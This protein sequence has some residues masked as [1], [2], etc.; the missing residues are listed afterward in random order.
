MIKWYSWIIFVT[1]GVSAQEILR[2]DVPPE[3]QKCY[4]DKFLQEKDNRFPHTLN[5]LIALI[6]KIEDSND[7][8]LRRLTIGIMHKFRLDGIV[9][10][11]NVPSKPGVSPYAP[12]LEQDAKFRR[13]L[14]FIPQRDSELND[15]LTDIERCSLHFMLS[16]SIE[17]FERGDEN[18]V[19]KVTNNAYRRRTRRA[20]S[21]RPAKENLNINDVETLTPEQIDGMI[22][23]KE[24][25]TEDPN[26]LYP[27]LPPNHPK[28]AQ[29]LSLPPYSDC[30]VENGVIKT[31][32]G[33]VSIGSVIAGIAAGL[34]PET[35]KLS[36][37]FPH[38]A[39]KKPNMSQLLVNNKWIATIAGDLAEV[40]LIQGPVGQK[41]TIG[42]NGN[43]NSSAEPH[44][45]FLKS[46]N[47]LEFT[48]A[49][50]RG[51][52][53]GL[54]LANEIETLYSRVPTLKLSQI[55]EMYYGAHGLFDHSIRACNRGI[56]FTTM[57]SNA[58][59]TMFAQTYSASMA[60]KEDL[61]IATLNDYVIEEFAKEAADVL[62]VNAQSFLKDD[63]S[64]E[65]TTTGYFKDTVE[66]SADLTIIL[67]T[68]WPFETIRPILTNLL[69]NMKINPYNS[70]FT[71]INARDG[72]IMMN[73]TDDILDFA[74]YNKTNYKNVTSGF[75]LS[76]TLEKLEIIQKTKLDIERSTLGN[77]KSDIILIIPYTSTVPDPDMP[78]LKEQLQRM[79]EQVPDATVFILTYR[80]KDRWLDYVNAE[81]LFSITGDE[82]NGALPTILDLVSKIRKVPQR[83]INTACGA[84][85]TPAAS[86]NPFD[87]Y[88]APNMAISY[89]M[90][91]NYFFSRDSSHR[92]TIKIEQSISGTPSGALKVCTSRLPINTDSSKGE[93][94]ECM[95]LSENAYTVSF[96][97]DGAEY[98][99]SCKPFYMIVFANSS[100][101]S[102]YQCTGQFCKFQNMMKY[103]VNYENL[104]CTSSASINLLNTII[105]ITS[106]IY[107]FS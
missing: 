18:V 100:V 95:I 1:L 47:S 29:I 6:R 34:Q 72:S 28:A 57:T 7:M 78:Y 3:L 41:L 50:I 11:P 15:E 107:V 80:S 16:G 31:N 71:I 93:N 53:D 79:Q 103:T 12:L 65:Q 9:G 69:E 106:I 13:I 70:Q 54:I 59:Q 96:S 97:C 76:K 84:N 22:N 35:V 66:L 17:I 102:S 19:C 36:E 49:E 92:S 90:H 74:N 81:N 99:H 68:T 14:T 4:D 27:A 87:G 46:N 63:L 30:P 5:T 40:V 32:W 89:R 85:Y 43:W 67:D 48:T 75:D 83:L 52:F 77:G 58:S 86:T 20:I 33:S 2:R 88:I 26:A 101:G 44:W 39:Q 98:I 62:S 64:C 73:T 8:D 82:K 94:V 61:Q 23:H 21:E 38:A 60:L 37:V 105:L 45:Y 24:T 56:L 42:S 25:G 91:P 55:L 51:N 104:V 10:N